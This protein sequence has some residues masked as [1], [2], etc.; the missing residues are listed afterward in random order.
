MMEALFVVALVAGYMWYLS[1]FATSRGG[2][3]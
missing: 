1:G 2:A 3:F